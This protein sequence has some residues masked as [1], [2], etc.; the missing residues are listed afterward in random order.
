[1]RKRVLLAVLALCALAVGCSLFEKKKEPL[2]GVRISVL[3][4]DRRLEP[5]P[6][7]ASAPVTLPPAVANPDWPQAGGEPD[8]AMH[9][10]ALPAA[11]HQ[12]WTVS[13]GKG[14]TNYAHVMAPPIV[15]G[16]RV[17][18]MDGASQVSAVDATAGRLLWQVDLKPKGAREGGFGGGVALWHGRLYAATGFGEVLALDAGSGKILWRHSV[19]TPIHA[20]P[21]VADGR[22]YVV[23]VENEVSVLSTEDGHKMWSHNGLPQTADLLGGASPAVAGDVV[24]VPYTSGEL[25]ALTVATGRPLWSES[26]AESRTADAVSSLA[27][28]RGRPVIDGDRVFA[29]GHSGR[30]EAIDLRTGNRVWEQEI[31]GTQSPWPVGGF[32]YMVTNDGELACLSR[33]TGKVRWLYQLPRWGNEKKKEDP[34]FWVGPVLGGDRLIIASSAS[35]LEEVSA[36]DG[37]PRGVPLRLPGRAFIAPIIA[38]GTLY[39]L[40]DDATLAAYR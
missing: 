22:I 6:Q 5:D 21:T 7:L 20:A 11:L 35:E 28:I 30:T 27:D 3:G 33:D 32:V 16:G 9:R 23:S 17:Y 15:G 29:V 31:G 10:L 24:V 26:L 4:L 39:I 8:H 19:G 40:T 37:R 13:V 1:M 18:A 38:G 25:Y 2:P 12:A 36:E 34:I 14:S